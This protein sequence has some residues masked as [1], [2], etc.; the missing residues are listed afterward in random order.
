MAS[1]RPLSLPRLLANRANAAASAAAPKVPAARTFGLQ[2]RVGAL[3]V[4]GDSRLYAFPARGVHMSTFAARKTQTE[5]GRTGAATREKTAMPHEL[6]FL[7][8]RDV[9]QPLA[10]VHKSQKENGSTARVSSFS[11]GVWRDWAPVAFARLTGPHRG[12]GRHQP[13][14]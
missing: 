11:P 1:L 8:E 14:D 4:G 13:A 3:L 7:P 5:E 12:G 9:Q 6:A 10:E 2:R